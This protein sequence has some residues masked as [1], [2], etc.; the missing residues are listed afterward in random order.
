MKR[1]LHIFPALILL[2]ASPTYSFA[3]QR[4]KQRVAVKG[5]AGTYKYVL[6]K[7]EILELPDHKVRIVFS[8]FW[9][10]DHK[11]VETR[12]VGGF[13]ETVPLKGRTAVVK[14]EYGDECAITFEFKPNRV[15]VTQEGYRC[16]F[17][18]NV[19]AEGSYK[20]VSSKPPDLPP[21]EKHT[22]D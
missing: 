3:D 4:P 18:F 9:P 22:S 16:G 12:N 21:P 19:E 2:F 6:N 14:P 11:R 15:E 13:D 5:I 7:L 20:K 17:G 10:N 1:H 8:G